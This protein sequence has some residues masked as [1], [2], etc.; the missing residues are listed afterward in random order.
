MD[1]F[2]LVHAVGAFRQAGVVILHLA[3]G[4][5]HTPSHHHSD[6]NTAKNTRDVFY[7]ITSFAILPLIWSR[8]VAQIDAEN[9][10]DWC[11]NKHVWNLW[12]QQTFIHMAATRQPALP[13]EHYSPYMAWM[14]FMFCVDI[15][16]IFIVLGGSIV[17]ICN[18]FVLIRCGLKIK[19]LLTV[20]L[21]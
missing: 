12:I 14:P 15:L 17:Y 7:F 1:I 6:L 20:K 13:S 19:L 18:L 5:Q 10:W 3:F 11:W 21:I 4:G 2:L 8:Q 16:C 9:F